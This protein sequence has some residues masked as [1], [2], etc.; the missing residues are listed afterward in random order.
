LRA[1]HIEQSSEHSNGGRFGMSKAGGC[2]R[3]ATLKLLGH[4][5]EPVS[6]STRVTFEIGHQVEVMALAMLRAM[7][8]TI[9][10]T[11]EPVTLDP[12]M[13]SASDGLLTD[14]PDLDIPYP[15]ILSV[16]SAAYKMSGQQKGRWVRRG[17]T[18]LPFDGVR[19]AQPSWWAQL[20]AEMHGSGRRYGL[21]LAVSKDI[22]KAFEKDPYMGEGGNGSLTFYAELI[23]YDPLFCETQL[24]PVWTE[25][26]ARVNEG[27]ASAP[28]Y[29]GPQSTYVRLPVAG[30]TASGWGG[31]NREATSTFNPC[32][33]CEMSAA[34]KQEL[35]K[36]YRNG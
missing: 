22:V 29:L 1:K 23:E 35:A 17:I 7:G 15:A 32:G 30:D 26:W 34:C 2:T 9:P 6:G 25:A 19:K 13:R 10:E 28:Y 5:A 16:K 20:Q 18:E 8:F 4:E 27:R 21:L 33:G 14:G 11:Q 24:L 36:E 3:A 12:F 31:P